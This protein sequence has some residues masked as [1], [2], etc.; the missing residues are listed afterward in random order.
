MPI[1][2]NNITMRLL[3]VCYKYILSFFVRANCATMSLIGEFFSFQRA[4]MT[5][6][7][8]TATSLVQTSLVQFTKNSKLIRC[9]F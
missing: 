5:L 8:I 7:K 4:I 6:V 1:G 2:A 3:P 9:A